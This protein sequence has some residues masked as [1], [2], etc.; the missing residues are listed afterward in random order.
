MIGKFLASDRDSDLSG[1]SQVFP[2]AMFTKFKLI[3][4]I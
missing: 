3:I 1:D 2:F 4:G